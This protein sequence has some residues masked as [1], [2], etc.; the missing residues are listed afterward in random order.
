M[1]DRHVNNYANA[2]AKNYGSLTKGIK[3]PVGSVLAKDSF[4]VTE[5]GKVF[6]GALF[7]MEKLSAGA[8]LDN[9]DWRYV[10][11]MPDGSLF[12]DSMGDGAEEMT[13]CH[14]CHKVKASRDYLYF[15]PKK[16]R[17]E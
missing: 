4:T 8:S 17:R 2:R 16:Y 12:G 15:V 3:L 1:P 14:V 10:M 9:A 5:E 7:V 6:A 13:F 11:I